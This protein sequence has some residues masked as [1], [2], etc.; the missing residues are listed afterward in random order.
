MKLSKLLF[1]LSFLS[2]SSVFADVKLPTIFSN[3]MMLQRDTQ[4]NV[5]GNA[6]D[7]EKVTVTFK[8]QKVSTVAQNGSFAVSLQPLSADAQGATLLIEGKNKI[9][10]K[11]VIVGDIWLCSGQSN[12]EWRLQNSDNGA[13]EIA[14]ANYP[15]IRLYYGNNYKPYLTPQVDNPN[16][17]WEVC[18]PATIGRFSGVAY[19]FAKEIN[20]ELNVPIGLIS[21]N[22]GGTRIEP[23]TSAYGF[24]TQKCYEANY[25]K[26]VKNIPGTPEYKANQSQIVADMKKWIADSEKAVAS[27]DY[28]P[29]TPESILNMPRL[30]N[31]QQDAVLFNSM[32]NPIKNF[33]IKGALWYQGCANLS[34]GML[35]R[36][37][38]HALIASWRKEFNMPTMPLYFVQLAPFTY[39]NQ[40]LLPQF[41]VAQQAF[42]DEDPYSKM[43]VIND[44]G[45]YK[46]IHPRNKHD[47]GHRL[48]LLALKY[49]Y[50][51][52]DLVADSPFFESLTREG[53][54]LVIT[55]RNAK[56]LKTTDGKAPKYFEIASFDGNFYPATAVIEG[57]TVKLASDKVTAPFMA[58]YAWNQ[59]VTTTLVN[60]NNLPAG[61]FKQSLPIP[62]RI[63]LDS[64][65]PEAKN[66]QVAYAL[67]IK[68][69]KEGNMV[70][71][72]ADN[73]RKLIGKKIKKIGYFL[74]LKNQTDT[75]FVYVEL[76][77]F[78]QDITKLGLPTAE[79]Q[80]Y[81]RQAV[82]NLVVKSNVA[83][84][85]CGK[86][87]LGNIEFWPCDYSMNNSAK[88]AGASDDK[89]DCGDHPGNPNR[90]GY[91]SLQIHNTAKSEVIL[92]LNRFNS[93]LCDVG[94][95]N[96]VSGGQPDYTF[97]Q[98]AKNY[99]YSEFLILVEVE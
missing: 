88:V 79:A 30:S 39:G 42:A 36:D 46:D 17:K 95:G 37:K 13:V 12:M 77:P 52:K 16:A 18:S 57:N 48:A 4:V 86:I 41:W 49:T 31:Q 65:V 53:S 6:D 15:A 87:A 60:E 38:M 19:F 28:L 59:N 8:N 96:N 75:K 22:W 7:G 51:K 94:I 76:D 71:Y 66:M 43:A 73:S 14:N 55:F 34:N 93:S 44:I 69:I 97:T 23:W 1:V 20:K 47:V 99:T 45:N 62:L 63:N 5:W 32:L 50:G 74:Y 83:N 3:D 67:P 70:N 25:A 85:T 10:I 21:A 92:A 84:L 40:Y 26:L 35:Y 56:Q 89:Y 80:I 11:N 81:F 78:T 61:A 98:S 90:N 24:S 54:S 9:E 68:N 27:N 58:R 2:C 33:R 72:I 82:K 91:G 64:L 29:A